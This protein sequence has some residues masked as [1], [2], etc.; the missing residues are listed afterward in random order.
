MTANFPIGTLSRRD[1]L[2]A[3]I[4]RVLLL[5]QQAEERL[6]I[7][8]RLLSEM[9]AKGIVPSQARA[10]SRRFQDLIGESYA[11]LADLMELERGRPIDRVESE[12]AKSRSDWD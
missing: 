6:Q 9:Q 3:E 7:Q 10:T 5:I 12:G 1:G 2:E 4:Q 8:E 11:H